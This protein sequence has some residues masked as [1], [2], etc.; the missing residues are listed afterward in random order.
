MTLEER[1]AKMKIQLGISDTSQDDLLE[2][3]LEDAYTFILGRCQSLTAETFPDTLE[4]IL[5][6]IAVIA[7]NRLGA[8]GEQGRT[9][10]AV[11]RTIYVLGNDLPKSI[12]DALKP[13]EQVMGEVRTLWVDS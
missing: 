11:S 12:L 8:E 6:Q 3:L 4:P 5:R 13:Y 7:Y 10:G 9:E 1:L 2:L